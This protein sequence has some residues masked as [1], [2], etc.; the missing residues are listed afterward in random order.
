MILDR[1]DA[2]A[3][4]LGMLINAHLDVQSPLELW[5]RSQH[6]HRQQ[7]GHPAAVGLSDSRR[8]PS[9]RVSRTRR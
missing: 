7:E 6:E 2:L 4:T 5:K 1:A 8:R 9:K 3:N